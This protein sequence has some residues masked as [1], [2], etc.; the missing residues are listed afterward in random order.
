MDA[1]SVFYDV[2]ARAAHLSGLSSCLALLSLFHPNF[3]RNGGI[4][5][6]DI[7]LRSLFSCA[8]L[9]QNHKRLEMETLRVK[10]IFEGIEGKVTGIDINKSWKN[11]AS[12]DHILKAQSF[13]YEI[14][15][16]MI[17]NYI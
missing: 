11:L 16:L 5:G 17:P 13:N 2:F 8:V 14:S 6:N 15:C 3:I 1:A 12:V 10:I 4:N 9:Q 7:Q